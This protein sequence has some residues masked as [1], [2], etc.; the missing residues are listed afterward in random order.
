MSEE[1]PPGTSLINAIRAEKSPYHAW[2][3]E[4][5]DNAFDAGATLV[6]LR[7]SSDRLEAK[8][9]GEGVL[10]KF[11]RAMVQI[12][13]HGELRATKLGRFGVGLKYK[14]IQ[15]GKKL[16]IQSVSKDGLLRRAVDWEVMRIT[17]KWTYGS[18]ERDEVP[19]GTPT[20]TFVS[21]RELITRE[22]TKADIQKTRT[23]IQRRYYPALEQEAIIELNGERIDSIEQPMLRDFVE[24][25]LEFPGGRSARVR[26]GMLAEP[27][28]AKLRQ[29]D[30]CIAYRVLVAESAFACDG[31]GGIRAMWGQLVLFGPWK[32]T[33]FKDGFA[34]DPY[35]DEL[36]TKVT[37]IIE[38]L[39]KQCESASMYLRTKHLELLLNEMLPP[40]QRVARP[41]QK[42]KLNRVGEKRGEKEERE[43]EDS[44]ENQSGPV[45]K[46]RPP[47]GILI[48]F[49]EGLHKTHGFGRAQ[50]GKASTRIQL[51]SDNPHISILMGFRDQKVAAIGLYAI[52]MLLY[53]GELQT[54]QPGMFD[55]PIGLRAWKLAGQQ[56]L[57]EAAE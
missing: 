38:P 23:E 17:N 25:T 19:A 47:R 49:A 10:K 12:S 50:T 33:K 41:K 57:D 9:N 44:E 31:Y 7:M 37:E 27:E 55:D 48:E 30:I 20:G 3:G 51:A 42:Q 11:D 13:E 39:L 18:A 43:T 1:L 35:E 40:A 21:I 5:L 2:A 56:T 53:E 16:Y 15:H 8:D 52:A 54:A 4:V 24:A 36:E 14:A 6:Q 29:I 32:I 28:T 45:K 22:P 46:K 26:A 34:E